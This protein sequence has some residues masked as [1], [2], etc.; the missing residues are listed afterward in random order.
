M[1][2]RISCDKDSLVVEVL[3]LSNGLSHWDVRFS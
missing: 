3:H 2:C 1:L